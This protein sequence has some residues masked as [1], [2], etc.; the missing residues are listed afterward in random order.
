MARPEPS[1]FYTGIVAALYG[2]LRSTGAPDPAPYAK[3]IERSG[4]PALELGCGF[5]EPLLDLCALGLDVEGL[6]ASPDMVAQCR[7][8]AAARGLN[9]AV[10]EQTV[11]DMQIERQFRSIFFA[12]PT[13]NLLPDDD[14]ALRALVRIREH[15]SPDGS[16]L[17]PLFIPSPT[18]AAVLGRPRV[19]VTEEGV[20]MRFTAVSERRDDAARVQATLTRYERRDGSAHE[21]EDREWLLH[22]YGI[23]DI[24]ALVDRAGLEVTRVL[25]PAGG[26]VDEHSKEFVLIVRHAPVSTS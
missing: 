17:L 8:N 9:V 6:D 26:P 25:N 15:L 3:F 11:E 18:P 22:W 20:E 10:H 13:F 14:T 24:R 16:L 19:H 23:A 1:Q 2:P 7:G 12:G 21:V 5:G 4:Q